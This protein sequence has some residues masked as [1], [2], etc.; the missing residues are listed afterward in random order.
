LCGGEDTD[1]NA[2]TGGTLSATGMLSGGAFMNATNDT[3]TGRVE[4]WGESIANIV[5]PVKFTKF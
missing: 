1:T 5:L 3:G 2:A 4:G